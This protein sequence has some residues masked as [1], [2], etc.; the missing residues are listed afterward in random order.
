M[1]TIAACGDVARNV[2][3]PPTPSTSPLVD[4]VLA[5]AKK[6]SSV[7]APKTPAYAAIWLDGQEIDFP[8]EAKDAYVDPLYGKTYLP[9]KFKTAFAF[10]PSTISTFLQM[11]WVSS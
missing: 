7:L 8:Q 9:R 2:M 6:L 4:H 10:H 5:E 11:T 1:T 3:A